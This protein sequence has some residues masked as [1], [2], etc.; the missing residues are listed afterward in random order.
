ML[1]ALEPFSAQ[2]LE[3]Q[4]LSGFPGRVQ[5]VPTRN[6]QCHIYVVTERPNARSAPLKRVFLR[7]GT[8]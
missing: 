5:Y 1:G 4:K 6:R 7:C 3:M 8:L 2:L